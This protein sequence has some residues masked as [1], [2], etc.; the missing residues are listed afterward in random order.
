[1]AKSINA[2]DIKTII[3]ACEAGIGSSL[4][5]VNALKKKMV[6]AK[7]TGVEVIHKSVTNLP[8]DAKFIVCHNQIKKSVKARAPEA[9]VMSFN[10]FFNDPLFDKLI[11]WLKEGQDIVEN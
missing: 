9:V 6:A 2:K 5:S 11:T 10:F 1:M 3:F 7:I 4:M 8:S